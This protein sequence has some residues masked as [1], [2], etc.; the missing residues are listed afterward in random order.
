MA[1]WIA[2]FFFLFFTEA[3]AKLSLQMDINPG[4]ADHSVKALIFSSPFSFPVLFVCLFYEDN[5]IFI[6]L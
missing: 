3:L 1:F 4:S 5:C 6:M 2:L